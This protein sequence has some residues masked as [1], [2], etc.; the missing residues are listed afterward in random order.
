MRCPTCGKE[1]TGKR[2]NENVCDKCKAKLEVVGYMYNG[3]ITY[4]SDN[5][6]RYGYYDY[7]YDDYYYIR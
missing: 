3:K 1:Y 7:S 6:N 5:R 4:Y 2:W